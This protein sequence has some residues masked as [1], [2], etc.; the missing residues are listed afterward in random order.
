MVHERGVGATGEWGEEQ[1]RQRTSATVQCLP[2]SRFPP[3]PSAARRRWG[4]TPRYTPPL[5]R[6][7]PMSRR[8]QR[9]PAQRS[10]PGSTGPSGAAGPSWQLPG[11]AVADEYSGSVPC[12]RLGSLYRPFCPGQA[13]PHD[14]ITSPPSRTN[15]T[16]TLLFPPHE[17]LVPHSFLS[18]GSTARKLIPRFGTASSVE[19]PLLSLFDI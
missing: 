16:P 15:F 5:G 10:V 2:K 1:G 7:C 11:T 3:L 14:Y 18:N 12:P 13:K 9:N 4:H 8:W 17:Y 19:Y 6:K